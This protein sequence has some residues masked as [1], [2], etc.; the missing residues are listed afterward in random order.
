MSFHSTKKALKTITLLLSPRFMSLKNRTKNKV[1]TKRSLITITVAILAL[2]LVFYLSVRLL[3]HFRGV[4]ILG[5]YLSRQLLSMSLL[6]FFG[7]LIF[8]SIITAL[9]NLYLSKDLELCHSSPVGIAPLFLSRSVMAI[10]DSSWMVLLFGIPIFSAYGVIYRPGP[11][12]YM[13]LAHLTF[14]MVVISGFIGILLVM[15]IS[16]LLPAKKARNIIILVNVVS[17][18]GLYLIFRFL[19]P[20]RLVNPEAFMDMTEYLAVLRAPQEPFLPTRWITDV[21]WNHL[22]KSPKSR[23]VPL[24]LLWNTAALMVTISLLLAGYIY[25]KGYSKAQEG[26]ARPA[27]STKLLEVSSTILTLPFKQDLKMVLEKDIRIFFRD[28]TQWTQLLLLCALLFVYLYNFSVL[29]LE[30]SPIRVDYLQNQLAF[31]NLGLA[32][33]VIAALCN[34]FVFPAIS[35]EGEGYWIIKTSPI[36]IKR[37]VIGKFYFYSFFI[38]L[39][40]LALV[41]VTNILLDVKG[42]VMW[43]TFSTIGLLSTG[44]VAIAIGLGCIFPRFRYENI[45]QV[46][47]GFGGFIFMMLAGGFIAATVILE[48]GPVYILFTAITKKEPITVLQWLYIISSFATVLL[49]CILAI[50]IPIKKGIKRLKSMESV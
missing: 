43:I 13:D 48:A 35:L 17:V 39:L 23:I 22:E 18:I 46:A 24:A 3:N 34:R 45:A 12:F 47:T 20:E 16:F 26:K 10:M 19:R 32:G 7:L 42:V 29:P 40:S 9:S 21:I 41:F 36:S 49:L 33:F 28:N 50:V 11:M 31:L 25:K 15:I 37:F 1:L 30:K 6:T 2:G 44:I 14:L 27:L 5:E 8:S 38:V 4:P